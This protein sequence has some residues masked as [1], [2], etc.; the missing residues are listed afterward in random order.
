VG[1]FVLAQGPKVTPLMETG[2]PVLV[3]LAPSWSWNSLDL[4]DTNS[5]LAIYNHFAWWVG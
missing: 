4:S 1:T 2:L 5:G 3:Y